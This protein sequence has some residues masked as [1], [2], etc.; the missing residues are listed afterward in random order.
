MDF[1]M[2]YL[3]KTKRN[4]KIL[5][6]YISR[7]ICGQSKKEYSDHYYVVEWNITR[8]I[9]LYIRRF[10]LVKELWKKNEQFPNS[11]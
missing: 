7:R 11:C 4:E 8:W 1:L 3:E 5:R 10:Y 9:P 6:Y 2:D